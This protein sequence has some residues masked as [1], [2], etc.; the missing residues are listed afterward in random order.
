MLAYYQHSETRYRGTDGKPTR[1]VEHVRHSLKPVRVLYGRPSRKTS[2][3]TN[4]R[5]CAASMVRE[6]L[7]LTTIRDRM[8]R[9]KRMVRWGVARRLV[10]ADSAHLLEAVE[11]LEPE[12]DGVRETEPV[13]PVERHD[14]DA[15]LEH[16]QPTIGAMIM[17]QWWSGTSPGEV[18]A[19]DDG[20]DRPEGGD[21]GLPTCQ[22][23]NRAARQNPRGLLGPEARAILTPLLKADPDA[24]IFSPRDSFEAR[25][26]ERKANRQTPHT[27]SS[28]AGSESVLR[29]RAPRLLYDKDSYAR[30]IRRACDKAGVPIF[31]P[32]RT[33]HAF[34]TRDAA[35]SRAAGSRSEPG[36]RGAR[37]PGVFTQ[38][39]AKRNEALAVRIIEEAG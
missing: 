13:E 21:M 18:I 1:E 27:P 11:A 9:V 8:S 2:G 30:A 14:V 28:R 17:L 5:P 35:S 33:R 4:S 24:P 32:N 10:P 19:N 36:S 23:Q 22:A 7:A 6:G 15:I 29:P 26:E 38:L 25:M 16:V 37:W 31:G 39:Y 34:G 12:R 20:A 3:R